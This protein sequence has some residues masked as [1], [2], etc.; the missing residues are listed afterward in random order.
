MP[1]GISGTGLSQH[2]LEK[3]WPCLTRMTS[4]YDQMAQLVG[5][6][7]AVVVFYLDFSE[8]WTPF[9]TTFPWRKQLLVAW[10]GA[11]FPGLELSGWQ[12]L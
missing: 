8:G 1:L 4:F 2:W 9:P 6:G 11:F 7:E 3:G 12:G 5:E 10:T